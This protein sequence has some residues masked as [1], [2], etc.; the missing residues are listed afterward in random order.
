MLAWV[1]TKTRKA[2]LVCNHTVSVSISGAKLVQIACMLKLHT[3]FLYMHVFMHVSVCARVCAC[4]RVANGRVNCGDGFTWVCE[5]RKKAIINMIR[6]RQ[7][8]DPNPNLPLFLSLPC[9]PASAF[10]VCG[11][12]YGY[13]YV[14]RWPEPTRFTTG[15]S[16]RT[17]RH[18]KR[19]RGVVVCYVCVAANK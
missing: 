19:A 4:V 9:S 15:C 7:V 14:S 1:Y 2:I 12:L 11:T 10:V 6:W 18:Q 5:H 8:R 3:P 17:T 16:M 13:M